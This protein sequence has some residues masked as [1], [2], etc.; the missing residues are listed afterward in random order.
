VIVRLPTT[1]C[2]NQDFWCLRLGRRAEEE[3][4]IKQWE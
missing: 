2:R 3:E 1:R 4:S